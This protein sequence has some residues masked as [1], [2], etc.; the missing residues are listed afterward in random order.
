MGHAT[1]TGAKRLAPSHEWLPGLCRD[2]VTSGHILRR[3]MPPHASSDRS[4]SAS[5][6]QLP[7]RAG[8]ASAP[9]THA[10]SDAALLSSA[11]LRSAIAAA[12]SPAAT[13]VFTSGTL[14]SPPTRATRKSLAGGAVL[15]PSPSAIR[16]DTVGAK[17]RFGALPLSC[18]AAAGPSLEQR[19]AEQRGC[20]SE[21]VARCG[22]A[23]RARSGTKSAASPP[24]DTD[25]GMTGCAPRC[26]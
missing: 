9:W 8:A 7:H 18:G 14:Q 4:A 22:K 24:P 16:P 19:V 6:T 20:T 25:S 3:R 2:P 17:H 23:G 5:D 10:E 26:S 11:T 21:G 15:T 13:N 1:R 12:A